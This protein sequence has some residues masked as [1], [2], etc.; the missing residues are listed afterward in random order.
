VRVGEGELLAVAVFGS[1]A[2]F[3]DA[4]GLGVS[5]GEPGRRRGGGSAKDDGEVMFCREGDG[6]VEP[7]EVEAAFGGLHGGPGELADAD[8]VHVGLFHEGEV[9]VPAVFGPLLGV[10]GGAEQKR[11]GRGWLRGFSRRCAGGEGEEKK[12]SAEKAGTLEQ[13]ETSYE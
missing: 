10:P 8:D 2:V 13:D 3:V 6:A 11:S 5:A 12:R 9:G 7:G 1:A 4:Q